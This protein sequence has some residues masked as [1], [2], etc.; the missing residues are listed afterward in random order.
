MT[1]EQPTM[2]RPTLDR[3]KYEQVVL[4]I[5]NGPAN[6]SLLGKVK[7]FKMLYYVDFNHCEFFDSPV[8]GDTY[9]KEEQGPFPNHGD[10]ILEQMVRREL[11]SMGKEPAGEFERF[12]FKPATEANLKVFSTSETEVLK[13]VVR[14]WAF[15]SREEI[16][17]ATH[18]EAPWRAVELHEEIPYSLTFYRH[19]P[20]QD[21]EELIQRKVG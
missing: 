9:R 12:V 17:E 6:N 3:I 7:L 4:F 21:D 10:E 8:T 19:Q 20:T 18:R 11:M 2:W 16:E 15:R 1:I 14:E 13:D 5:L